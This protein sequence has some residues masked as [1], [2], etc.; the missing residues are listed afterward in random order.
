ML[1]ITKIY[2]KQS[3]IDS[4]TLS[5]GT[6]NDDLSFLV[7]NDETYTETKY[8]CKSL[9]ELFNK[10]EIKGLSDTKTEFIFHIF[11]KGAY[12]LRNYLQITN[13]YYHYAPR[14]NLEYGQDYYFTY[15]SDN[16]RYDL[17]T[18]YIGEIFSAWQLVYDGLINKSLHIH[19]DRS[20]VIL[21]QPDI[22]ENNLNEPFSNS[23]RAFRIKSNSDL[24][25]FLAKAFLGLV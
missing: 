21:R 25:I 18:N 2:Y 16:I 24:D 7:Y 10:V 13:D 5:L 23:G 17:H 3:E 1:F 6:I 19:R 14:I 12:E 8:F 4:F 9:L 15:N 20:Y 11:T 22:N